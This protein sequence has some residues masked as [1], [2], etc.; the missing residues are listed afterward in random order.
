MRPAE[1]LRPNRV[2]WGPRSTSTRLDLAELGE[3]DAR[4]R[5]I[6]AVD[7]HRDRAFEA[8][9]VADRADAA[10]TGRAVGFR[11]GRRDEQRRGELVELADVGGAGVLASRRR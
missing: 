3:A 9:V 8:G 2:P 6:D 4:T 1:A 7:E 11:A 10:D 5:A